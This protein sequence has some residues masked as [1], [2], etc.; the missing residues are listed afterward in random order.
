MINRFQFCYNF[1]FNFNL[2]RYIL[3]P[4]LLELGVNP[5]HGRTIVSFSVSTEAALS[6]T[7]HQGISIVPFSAST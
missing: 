1:A 2:R 4:L 6:L 5:R 3:G 7:P